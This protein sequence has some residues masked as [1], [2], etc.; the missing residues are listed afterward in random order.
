MSVLILG[1]DPG[2]N[3][4]G[5]GLLEFHYS[6]P[7]AIDYGVIQIDR[8]LSFPIRLQHIY[9]EITN[10]LEQTHPNVVLWKMYMSVKMQRQPFG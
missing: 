5:Y 4:V 3:L 6:Q 8:N 7:K 9:R 10:L 2:I 1:I